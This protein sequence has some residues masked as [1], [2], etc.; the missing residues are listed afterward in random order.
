[1]ML[2]G[3]TFQA[4]GELD[5]AGADDVLDLEVGK[6]GVEAELLDDARV[7]ARSKLGVGLG[8]GTSNDHLA[9][10][11]DQSSGLGLTNT[12]DDSGKTLR[13]VLGVSRVKGD[14]LQ[15]QSARQIDRGNDVS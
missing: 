1:M 13:V 4:H 7:L 15:V 2:G 6:F 14:R 5:V 3:K 11:K 10:G 8:L 9:T 12:H